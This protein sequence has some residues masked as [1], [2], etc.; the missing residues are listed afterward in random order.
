MLLLRTNELPESEDWLYEI[1]LD[2]CR[3]IAFK[4]DGKVHL[5]SRNNND[6]S[7]RYTEAVS[8]LTKLPESHRNGMRFLSTLKRLP[9]LAQFLGELS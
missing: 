2:G 6:F 4:S 1:K 3:A 9:P 7:S 5:R 8:A